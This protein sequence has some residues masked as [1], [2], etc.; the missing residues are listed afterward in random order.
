MSETEKPALLEIK[1]ISGQPVFTATAE[2]R[3]VFGASVLMITADGQFVLGEGAQMDDAA[4]ALV[5][6]A[7]A[8]HVTELAR[9]RARADAAEALLR[10]A[11]GVLEPFARAADNADAKAKLLAAEGMHSGQMTPGTRT[12][13]GI[14]YAYVADARALADKIREHTDAE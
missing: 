9:E 11:G 4:R 1:T 7:E 14:T 5:G 13:W 2:M 12:A 10:E 6:A 8:L 3:F